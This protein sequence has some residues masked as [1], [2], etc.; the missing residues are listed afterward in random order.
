VQKAVHGSPTVAVLAFDSDLKNQLAEGTLLA[1]DNQIDQN[2]GTYKIKGIFENKDNM[3]FPNQM[4]NVRLRVDVRRN[5]V[6]VPTQAIQRSPES[7]FVFVLLPNGTAE[8]RTVTP[9]P[10]EAGMTVVESGVAEG[11]EVAT[12]GLDRLEE[13]SKVQIQTEEEAAGSAPG[14]GGRGKGGSSQTQ[15]AGRGRGA[16]RDMNAG[17]GERG[18]GGNAQ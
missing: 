16:A 4:V 7:T 11:E 6:M 12:E 15:A 9:G 13:G 3:L 2:S 8:E 18:S 5:V 1:I 17:S 14:R 10:A